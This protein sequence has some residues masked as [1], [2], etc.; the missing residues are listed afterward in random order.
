[1]RTTTALVITGGLLATLTACST[2]VTPGPAECQPPVTSGTASNLVEATGVVGSRPTVDFPTPIETDETQL[3]VLTAGSGVPV[4][5]GQ[6]VELEYTIFN[7][8]T[9]EVYEETTYGGGALVTVGESAVSTL[10]ASLECALPGSRVAITTSGA[11][12]LQENPNVGFDPEASVVFVVDVLESYLGRADGVDQVLQS[13]FPS[14]VLGTD[15]TPGITIPSGVEKPQETRSTVLKKGE[16][17]ELAQNDIAVLH[18]SAVSWDDE[19]VL[20]STWEQGQPA[21][22]SLA[23]PQGLPTPVI[24]ALVGQAVGSQ[25]MVLVPSEQTEDSLVIV[26]DI[27]GVQGATE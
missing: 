4:R 6:P 7:G 20:A 2:T 11:Q 25:I 1:V 13:D 10:T 24:D 18:Y 8:D 15:G 19:N 23:Q 21:I 14:V 5:E 12:I 17:Q 16:G 22:E 9:G 27:L 3:S 26:V